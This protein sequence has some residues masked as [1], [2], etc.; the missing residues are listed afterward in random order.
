MR[1]KDLK[2]QIWTPHWARCTAVVSSCSRPPRPPRHL[3]DIE[4]PPKHIGQ[5]K[6]VWWANWTHRWNG[7]KD[8]PEIRWFAY[9]GPRDTLRDTLTEGATR[10]FS[11]EP[12][13]AVLFASSHWEPFTVEG[14]QLD[15]RLPHVVHKKIRKAMESCWCYCEIVTVG[16]TADIVM[17]CSQKSSNVS[18]NV[19]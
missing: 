16:C 7:N 10:F 1:R 8:M 3:F 18:S 12:S 6:H 19:L 17:M 9:Q 13:Q 15:P 11:L 5:M 2:P 4:R 14:P